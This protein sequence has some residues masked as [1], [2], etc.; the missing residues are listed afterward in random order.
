MKYLIVLATF[1]LSTTLI[2]TD[3]IPNKTQ[4]IREYKDIASTETKISEL[5]VVIKENLKGTTVLA[6]FLTEHDK[7]KAYRDAHIQTLFPEYVNDIKMNWGTIAG[8]EAAQE[9]IKMNNDR[10]FILEKYINANNRTGTDGKGFF[11]KYVTELR[12]I[13]AK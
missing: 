8:Y 9:I 7:W 4:N 10:I 6:D 11:K 2:Y 13:Q 1:I 3:K 5:I 12:E